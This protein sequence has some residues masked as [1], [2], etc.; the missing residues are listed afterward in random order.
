[1]N[2]II[3]FFKCFD[4]YYI[5]GFLPFFSQKSRKARRIKERPAHFDNADAAVLMP[6]HQTEVLM[7]QRC[8]PTPFAAHR[9]K[10]K[11]D[12]NKTPYPM[13]CTT[14]KIIGMI[15]L[16]RRQKSLGSQR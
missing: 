4:D 7:S 9:P 16:R 12:R 6:W 15:K 3:Y 2:V 8:L 11:R 13:V 5:H 14:E 10:Y 1:M